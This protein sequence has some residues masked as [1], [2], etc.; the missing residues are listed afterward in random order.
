[1]RKLYLNDNKDVLTDILQ[2]HFER[3]KE[4]DYVKMTDIKSILKAGGIK[5]KDVITIRKLIEETFEDVEFK[6]NS[7]IKGKAVRN[8]F[9]K[10]KLK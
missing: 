6:D 10:L 8:F 9:V 2:E 7:R 3:G 5:E 1:M 4:D